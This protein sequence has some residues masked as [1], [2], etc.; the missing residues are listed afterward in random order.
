MSLSSEVRETNPA[1]RI[2]DETMRLLETAIPDVKSPS[3]GFVDNTEEEVF[4]G[5]ITSRETATNNYKKVRKLRRTLDVDLT[6]WRKRLSLTGPNDESIEEVDEEDERDNSGVDKEN[7]ATAVPEFEE[8]IE[9]HV[10]APLQDL[11]LS[12][13]S[14][15]KP[16]PR[17]L[18]SDKEVI[19][20]ASTSKSPLKEIEL[21]VVPPTPKAR[22]NTPQNVKESVREVKSASK[23]LANLPKSKNEEYESDE[24]GPSFI[25]VDDDQMFDNSIFTEYDEG[26]LSLMTNQMEKQ[27]RK[28]MKEERRKTGNFV[29]AATIGDLVEERDKE[30]SRI[31]ASSS[32]CKMTN[33]IF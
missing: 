16:S 22:K 14:P 3:K 7:E 31:S 1:T 19:S 28:K 11:R 29:E 15:P 9:F 30:L 17:K 32:N 33:L 8:E 6:A 12:Q 23:L 27:W 20:S 5:P 13:K 2:G 25:N 4:F 10:N 26:N 24:E 18:R 21:N